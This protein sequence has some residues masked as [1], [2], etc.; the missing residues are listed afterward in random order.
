MFC[1]KCGA[2][3]PDGASFC[4]KCG[5]PVG[6][7]AAGTGNAAPAGAPYY[8]PAP[9]QPSA[10][11]RFFSVK[12]NVIVTAVIAVVLI[13]VIVVA[14][15][16]AAMPKK[17]FVDDYF[18][19]V[20]NGCDGYATPR[21]EWDEEALKKVNKKIFSKKVK[22][23]NDELGLGEL[24]NAFQDS[25]S[26]DDCVDVSLDY[27][28]YQLSNG[29]KINVSVS[30]NSPS[31]EE[32]FKIKL[33]LRHK[34]V[35]VKGL[36]AAAEF[37]PFAGITLSYEGYTGYG[38]ISVIV[39]DAPVTIGDTG[40]SAE[41]RSASDGYT[42]VISDPASESSSSYMIR[43]TFER[44]YNLS[45]DDFITCTVQDADN[46]IS[47]IGV[48]LTAVE[49]SFTLT[50]FGELISYDP[51]KEISV[52]FSGFS[53]FGEA[54]ISR[55][56]DKKLGKYIIKTDTSVND[57]SIRVAVILC[58][59]NGNELRTVYYDAD[60]TKYFA[61]SDVVTF[62]L[63]TSG[64]TLEENYGI[65]LAESFAITVSGLDTP[66]DPKFADHLSV[67]FD[68]FEGYGKLSSFE[69]INGDVYT[70]GK[71]TFKLTA[72]HDI[73][74]IF[75]K[76][77]LSVVVADE[78]GNLFTIEY[79]AERYR[80]LEKN[81]DVVIF[82]CNT[83]SYDREELA[84][85]YGIAFPDELQYTVSG[86]KQVTAVDPREMLNFGFSGENGKI[87][88][89]FGLKQ[90][91]MTVGDYKISLSVKSE[92]SWGTHETFLNFTFTGS[93]GEVFTGRYYAYSGRLSE[94]EK[95]SIGSSIDISKIAEAT[96]L[97]F[98]TD[99]YEVIVSTK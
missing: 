62:S 43:C 81:G 79:R 12:R 31:F 91:E 9:A 21:I 57:Y 8:P 85:E 26:L 75:G 18:D 71:Y 22:P 25:L 67:A 88:L 69:I 98:A 2:K 27:E 63:N 23:K 96:G 50:G 76:C 61:N 6:G 60:K 73:E 46:I 14:V 16:V 47:A 20:Y 28:K 68:G 74:S 87:V 49:K 54:A 66:V 32:M 3:I 45:N 35:T 1:E 15:I 42:I 30:P 83:S 41:Y 72:T 80:N 70:S 55:A 93:D 48:S 11:K 40:L 77:S 65:T 92:D 44:T 7:A 38:R 59:E 78:T 86:L 89:D 5:S 97:L 36:K 56:E 90:A 33:A 52:S 84:R 99:S 53:G 4:E 58:D 19:I 17:I 51:S 10:L 37:D 13:A 94:G 95:L 39:P 82:Y 64:T 29:D 24:W 34:T